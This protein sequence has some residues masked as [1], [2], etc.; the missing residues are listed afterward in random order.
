MGKKIA[1]GGGIGRNRV[2]EMLRTENPQGSK[3]LSFA[4]FFGTAKAV[5]SRMRR[6]RIYEDASRLSAS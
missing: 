3:P 1:A 2:S 5:P 6:T 4:R